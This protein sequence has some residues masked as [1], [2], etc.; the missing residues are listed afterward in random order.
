MRSIKVFRGK[1][2]LNEIDLYE[3]LVEGKTIDDVR[4]QSGDSILITGLGDSIKVFGEVIRPAIYEL[5]PGET[6]NHALDF[7]LGFTH[8]QI[9]KT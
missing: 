6:L 1:S 4:I 5:K 9:K 8:L 2:L 7:A 3:L